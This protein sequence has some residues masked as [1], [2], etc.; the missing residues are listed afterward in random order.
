MELS[1]QYKFEKRANELCAVFKDKTGNPVAFTEDGLRAQI[2]QER[3][4]GKTPTLL[5]EALHELKREQGIPA[6]ARRP[7]R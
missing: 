1:K 7:A 4:G 3:G 6:S 2:E 5:C